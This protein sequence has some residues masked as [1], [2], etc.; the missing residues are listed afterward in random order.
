MRLRG[1]EFEFCT[2]QNIVDCLV[3]EGIGHGLSSY[4]LV[5]LLTPEDYYA[6]N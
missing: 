2:F 5:C 3:F 6:V 1:I 4:P